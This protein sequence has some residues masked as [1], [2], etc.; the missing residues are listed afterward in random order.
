[1]FGRSIPEDLAQ[2]IKPLFL[3][4]NPPP[5]NN[6]D[7]GETEGKDFIVFPPEGEIEKVR[8]GAVV[9]VPGDENSIHSAYRHVNGNGIATL[10]ARNLEK[11]VPSFDPEQP[12]PPQPFHGKAAIIIGLTGSWNSHREKTENDFMDNSGKPILT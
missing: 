5:G 6:G 4:R 3:K 9:I 2:T 1:L 8:I 12:F 7:G 11:E 10:P